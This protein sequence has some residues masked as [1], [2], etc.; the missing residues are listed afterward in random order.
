MRPDTQIIS[1][2]LKYLGM[3]QKILAG[4]GIQCEYIPKNL[5]EV[6]KY[7]AAPKSSRL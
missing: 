7:V 3:I 2:G 5:P 1:P 6:R 4:P